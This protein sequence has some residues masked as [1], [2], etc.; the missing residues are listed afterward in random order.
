M[1]VQ[2]WGVLIFNKETFKKSVATHYLIDVLLSG[3][4]LCKYRGYWNL[5]GIES[6][7]EDQT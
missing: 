6:H 5:R 1:Q 3:S 7:L 4:T 2:I